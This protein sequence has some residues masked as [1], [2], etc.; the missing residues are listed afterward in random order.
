LEIGAAPNQLCFWSLAGSPYQIYLAA[1]LPDAR[2][3]VAALS[4]HLLQKGNPWL[5]TNGYISFDRA[6]NGNGVTWGNLPDIKPFIKSAGTGA[7]GWLFAGLLPDT[8][9]V[10]ASPPA[11]M[12]N[13]VL[14]RTNLV[15]YDWEVTGP[16]LEPVLQLGQTARQIAH[17]PRMAMDSSAIG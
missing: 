1:P 5:S 16:R 4:D 3:Q 6:T 7:A 8:N 11:G 14:R 13:D 17:R 2:S 15:Y 10:A 12:I 9:T